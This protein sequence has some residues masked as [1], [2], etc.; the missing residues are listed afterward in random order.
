MP[1][2]YASAVI[3]SPIDEV[4]RHVHDFNNVAAWH[5]AVAESSIEDAGQGDRVGCIRVLRM[6]DGARVR[7]RLTALSDKDH[8]YSYS[9]V[10]SPFPIRGHYS[11]VSFVPVTADGRTFVQWSA[12]F[13]VTAGNAQDVV[14]GVVQ[15]TMLPG[16]A[17]LAR[18]ARQ[19]Q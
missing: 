9:V 7:E 5:P 11:T 18:V 17:G 3:D 6:A 10:E 8:S 2:A 16:F 4:W 19:P 14:D 1:R 13:E 12:E 15:G